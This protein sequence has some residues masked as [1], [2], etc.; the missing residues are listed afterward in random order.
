MSFRNLWAVGLVGV[1]LQLMSNVESGAGAIPAKGILYDQI[2]EKGLN[3]TR[4]RTRPVST[5]A[6]GTE[7]FTNHTVV[8][9]NPGERYI[10]PVTGVLTDSEERIDEYATGAV[11]QRGPVRVI[12]ALDIASE[13][14]LDIL[15]PDG[16]RLRGGPVGLSIMNP[17]DGTSTLIAEVKSSKGKLDKADPRKIVFRD[18]LD[19]VLADCDYLVGPKGLSQTIVLRERIDPGDWGLPLES[20]LEVISSFEASHQ[21]VISTRVLKESAGKQANMA[22]PSLTD[23]FLNFGSLVMPQGAAFAVADGN[24][25]APNPI[26]FE[27]IPVAKHWEASVAGAGAGRSVLFE[28]MKCRRWSA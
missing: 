19:G 6:P 20:R 23:S 15:T 21:P 18:F 22:S 8:R 26:K 13:N 11:Y 10:D 9:I 12:F 2:V 7:V 17:V 4:F 14:S 24:V 28:S 25:D 3:H 1:L 5:N 27:S 16:K